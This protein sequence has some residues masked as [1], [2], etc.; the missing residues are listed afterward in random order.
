MFISAFPTSS[1]LSGQFIAEL[2]HI[3]RGE[4]SYP[5]NPITNF[6]NVYHALQAARQPGSTVR[7]S[8]PGF[9]QAVRTAPGCFGRVVACFIQPSEQDTKNRITMKD[10]M[11]LTQMIESVTPVCEALIEQDSAV[12]R[13]RQAVE[14]AELELASATEDD[15]KTNPV[16]YRTRCQ[17]AKDN[18]EVL[19]F[20]LKRST[21]KLAG[22]ET[23]LFAHYDS[24]LDPLCIAM[25]KKRNKANA[26]LIARLKQEIHPVEGIDREAIDAVEGFA[27]VCR[28]VRDRDRVIR[29]VGD[30]RRLSVTIPGNSKHVARALMDAFKLV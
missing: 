2:R 6:Q 7:F 5:L 22:L 8:R 17:A 21:E 9:Q 3:R 11:T 15:G 30:S 27:L 24:I 10:S 1:H 25:T 29:W 23:E 20:E 16:E 12:E 18:L 19:K 28:G 26:D 13:A 4:A 14:A